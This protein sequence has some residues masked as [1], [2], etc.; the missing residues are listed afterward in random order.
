MAIPPPILIDDPAPP[1]FG[2][3]GRLAPQTRRK[4]ATSALVATSR[5]RTTRR[6]AKAAPKAAEALIR[7]AE[8]GD[9]RAA[10][11]ILDRV[12]GRPVQATVSLS[13]DASRPVREMTDDQLLAILSRHGI[14]LDGD[15]IIDT[16]AVQPESGTE[17]G[18][19]PQGPA[20]C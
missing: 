12:L 9:T 10:D 1:K 11:S 15:R 20:G 7:K 16:V 4:I 5:E 3:D 18:A 19:S 6:L 17:E 13:V 2:A 14:D 8:E